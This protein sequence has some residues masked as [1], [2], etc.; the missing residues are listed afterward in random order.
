MKETLSKVVPLRPPPYLYTEANIRRFQADLKDIFL[1]GT[2]PMTK[3]YLR[4]LVEEIVV[5]ADR[6]EISLEPRSAL[7]M[8]S[9]EG[10]KTESEP[11]TGDPEV[12]ILGVS[13]LRRTDSNR[14]PGG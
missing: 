1:S 7:A 4:F 5:T 6:V 11:P 3:N 9:A 12:L 14:R 13:W 8:M 10:R 2:T